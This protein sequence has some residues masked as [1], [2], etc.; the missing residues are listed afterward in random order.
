CYALHCRRCLAHEK[1]V[2]A[3]EGSR[4]AMS[5][6][7]ILFLSLGAIFLVLALALFAFSHARARTLLVPLRKPLEKRPEQFGLTVEEVRISSPRGT[8]AAWYLPA[9]NGCTL[10]CCHG[11]HDNRGQW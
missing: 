9:R 10:I 5:L 4:A 3:R 7:S 11:I 1:R 6:G 8:L 2:M